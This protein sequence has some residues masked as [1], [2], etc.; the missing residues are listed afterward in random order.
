MK[1]AQSNPS[2]VATDLAKLSLWLATLARDHEFS[3]LDHALKSGDSLVGLRVA[4]NKAQMPH[5]EHYAHHD[6]PGSFQFK[7]R[8][9]PAYEAAL[10]SPASPW[11]GT[12]NELTSFSMCQPC[13]MDARLPYDTALGKALICLI[14]RWILVRQAIASKLTQE[15]AR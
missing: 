12:L 11:P 7:H 14:L 8:S 13:D 3:L 10:F 15:K 2:R 4:R 9:D 1:E 6:S 5:Y